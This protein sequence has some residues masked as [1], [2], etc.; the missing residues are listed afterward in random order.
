MLFEGM[1]NVVE[2]QFLVLDEGDQKIQITKTNKLPCDHQN[3]LLILLKY[4]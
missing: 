4:I 3:G 2:K 1:N